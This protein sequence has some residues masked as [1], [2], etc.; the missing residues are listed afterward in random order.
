MG[1]DHRHGGACLTCVVG[2]HRQDSHDILRGECK[3]DG[4][5]LGDDGDFIAVDRVGDV[6]SESGSGDDGS[7]AGETQDLIVIVLLIAVI[8]AEDD[9]YAVEIA[10]AG[11][12]P[13]RYRGGKLD[14]VEVGVV[15]AALHFI[16]CAEFIAFPSGRSILPGGVGAAGLYQAGVDIDII[17]IPEAGIW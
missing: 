10:G 12:I 17:Y 16:F 6:F 7:G 3:I 8:V 2:A 4:A 13:F 9:R 5:L 11:A 14:A 15:G 1:L